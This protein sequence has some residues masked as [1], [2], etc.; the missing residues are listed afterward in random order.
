[1]FVVAA[2]LVQ[3]IQITI[4][5]FIAFI[6]VTVSSLQ[7]ENVIVLL[8]GTVPHTQVYQDIKDLL[9]YRIKVKVNSSPR[10]GV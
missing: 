3:V 9:V 1:M 4:S 7:L 8:K 5:S 2:D 10:C 6:N